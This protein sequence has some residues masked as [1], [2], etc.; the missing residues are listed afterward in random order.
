MPSRDELINLSNPI[1]H[2]RRSNLQ[3][4]DIIHRE[5]VEPPELK[6]RAIKINTPEISKLT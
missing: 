1:L 4:Q 5:L 6:I 3:S 2:Y